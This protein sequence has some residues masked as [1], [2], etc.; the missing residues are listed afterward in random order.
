MPFRCCCLSLLTL[1]LLGASAAQASDLL[2]SDRDCEHILAQHEADPGTL[3]RHL[4]A[5][6]QERLAAAAAAIAP[7]AGGPPRAAAT[8]PCAGP[9][10]GDSVFCWG[11]WAA[12]APAAAGNPAPDNPVDVSDY[13]LRPELASR[14]DNAVAPNGNG[15]LPLGSCA[16]GAPCGFATVVAGITSSA[17]ADDTRFARFELA[18]DGSQF[19]VRP[20]GGGQIDSVTGMPGLITARPDQFENLTAN[21]RDGELRSRQVARILRDADGI[22]PTSGDTGTP[23]LAM[24]TRGTS[25]GAGQ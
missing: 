11:P 20:S 16:P 1:L 13:D 4:V 22:V 3:P 5:E 2:L 24:R 7:A 12:L 8:D 14:F 19:T 10:A 18:A 25:P 17:P 15:S 23:A 21:G 6:C 9:G